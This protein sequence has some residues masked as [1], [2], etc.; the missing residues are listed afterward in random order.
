MKFALFGINLGPSAEP[1]AMQR[2][3]Q[4][5]EAA[6][7]ESVWTG[8]HVVLPDPQKPPSPAPPLLPFVHPFTALAYIAAT[9]KTLLLGTGITLIAQRNALV[10]AK[11]AASLD[12]L[13]GGRLLFGIGAGYLQPEFAAL[14]L[15][16]KQRGARTDEYIDAIREVWTSDAP[17][18]SG[19]FV[20]F[21][22][23]QARPQP[24]QPGGPPI[25]VGGTSPAAC[26]RA[27]QKGQGWYG[28][29]LNVEESRAAVAALQSAAKTVP[30][31]KALG[32]L[33]ISITPRGQLTEESLAAFKEM[34]VSRLILLMPGQTAAEQLAFIEAT[35][36]TFLQ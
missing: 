18:F 16:F 23:I 15:D 5:A 21:A 6:G 35:A 17:A 9:T 34:G 20:N 22:G 13:S 27:Q 2:L 26:R 10:L 24:K 33:E 4:A 31:D 29:A 7:F 12:H 1:A 3:A 11:E 30:R 36:K 8:E 14:G 28:F 32:P 25:I 19:K